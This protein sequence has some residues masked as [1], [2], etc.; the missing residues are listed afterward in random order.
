MLA[1]DLGRLGAPPAILA[2]ASRVVTDEARHVEICTAVLQ[3]LHAEPMDVPVAQRR[4]DLGSSDDIVQRT[5]RVLVAGFAV[6]EPMSAGCFAASRA[7]SSNPLVRWAL[8]ELL[9]DEAR[10]GSFGIH[11][12]TWLLAGWPVH[13]RQALWPF[14]VAEMQTFERRIGGPVPADH[15]DASDP[16]ALAFGILGRGANCAAAMSAV[17]R[18]VIPPLMK[19]GIAVS[20][21]S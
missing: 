4:R 8:T 21:R 15:A 20:E 13:D 6:G 12:A 5:A 18:W 1:A 17:E 16:S 10:H 11:A 3:R 7:A 9:R 19:L 14:C 2:E